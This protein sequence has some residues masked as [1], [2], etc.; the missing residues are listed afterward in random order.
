M[1]PVC[2]VMSRDPII[3]V[4][5]DSTSSG[6]YGGGRERERERERGVVGIH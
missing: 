2:L 3:L 4:A 5:N 6:L 1:E